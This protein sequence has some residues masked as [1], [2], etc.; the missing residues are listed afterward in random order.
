MTSYKTT[1]PPGTSYRASRYTDQSR[2]RCT[3]YLGRRTTLIIPPNAHPPTS[4]LLVIPF[5]W[6]DYV[7]ASM[8]W[9]CVLLLA[10]GASL[11]VAAVNFDGLVVFFIGQICFH[12]ASQSH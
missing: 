10:L 4:V 11:G 2:S 5:A 3:K 6:T 9:N 1:R 7:H 12:T 8:L